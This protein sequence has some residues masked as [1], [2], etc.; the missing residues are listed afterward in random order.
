MN[1]AV[2]GLPIDHDSQIQFAANIQSFF[3]ENLLNLPAFRTRLRR[4]ERHS[5]NF[6]GESSPH[7]SGVFASFHA[8][9]LAA[10]AGMDLRF[11]NDNASQLLGNGSR[12]RFGIGNLA[13]WNA[14]AIA[15]KNL[16]SLVFVYLH[17]VLSGN[18]PKMQTG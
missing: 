13:A 7:P 18:K 16:L 12:L 10:P 2:P 4:D 15:R 1:T 8:A 3:D 11:H 5:Q 14:H 6:S 17:F 9:A